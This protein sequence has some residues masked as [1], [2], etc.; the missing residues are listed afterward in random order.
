MKIPENIQYIEV[1]YDGRCG[2]CCTFHEWVN[3]QERN[4]EVRFV[5]Y[6]DPRAEEWFRGVNELEPEREMIVRTDQGKL[7]R[8]AE[9]W[10]LCLLSCKKYQQIARRLAHPR[11]LPFAEKTC[12]A[13]A[14][15]MHKL[16]KIFFNKKDREVAE[17]LH[18]IPQKKVMRK[19]RLTR[20]C[21]IPDGLI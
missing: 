3:V 17:N 8:A 15:R 18:Q 21:Y 11:L 7:Y 16:S 12:H 5:A 6:Q 9:G 13:L 19:Q 14:A 4:Y 1:Y 10:V 20:S 2:M